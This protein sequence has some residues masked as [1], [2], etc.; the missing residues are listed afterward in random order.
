M[1]ELTRTTNQRAIHPQMLSGH[2]QGK[3]LEMIV[4][5]L[6]PQRILEIGTFTGYSALSMAA[7][8]DDGAMLD[9]IEADDELEEMIRSY[10][11]RSGFGHRIN[12]HIGSALQIIPS[13]HGPYDMVFMDG[14]K[15]EYPAYYEML[16]KGLDDGTGLL[17]E[18][19]YILADNI[20]WYG[21]VAEADKTDPHTEAIRKFNR[22]V[23]EDPRMDNIIL[24][25]RDGLN[26]IRVR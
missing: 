16:T 12:L 24:P 14:D 5:M 26:I 22:M 13:L 7:G 18:G 3:F 11:A 23:L 25:L 2:V 4:R 19:S 9:T 8:L 21:K 10:F 6:H 1:Q 20:L 15:R 17:H